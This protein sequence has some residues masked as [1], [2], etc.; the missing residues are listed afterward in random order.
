MSTV[1]KRHLK[2]KLEGL[3]WSQGKSKIKCEGEEKKEAVIRKLN[4]SRCQRMAST[5]TFFLNKY[6][7]SDQ[8]LVPHKRGAELT[9]SITLTLKGASTEKERI[10]VNILCSDL[11]PKARD[12]VVRGHRPKQQE[13]TRNRGAWPCG[14][15][16][17]TL[18]D[19]VRAVI[20]N[21]Q[22]HKRENTRLPFVGSSSKYQLLKFFYAEGMVFGTMTRQREN[23]IFDI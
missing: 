12:P 10:V 14:D 18:L 9:V 13:T 1:A 4:A 22:F 2:N 20:W 23:S 3:H 15:E 17:A 5:G 11:D 6:L 16:P 7:S 19:K 21:K 8:V